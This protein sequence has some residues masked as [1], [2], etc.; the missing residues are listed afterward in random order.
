MHGIDCVGNDENAVNM[1]W[2]DHPCIQSGMREIFRN[3]TNIRRQRCPLR[4]TPSPHTQCPRTG[5]PILGALGHETGANPIVIISP[6]ANET[7]LMMSI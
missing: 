4:S 3:L 1:V 2:H 5:Y 7:A 6:Q